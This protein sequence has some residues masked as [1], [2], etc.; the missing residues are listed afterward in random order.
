MPKKIM[1]KYP[2]MSDSDLLDESKLI[3]HKRR[4]P[5]EKLKNIIVAAIQTAERKSSRAILNL[6]ED[7][8]DEMVQLTYKKEGWE[9]FKYFIKYCGDP[10]S[11]ACDYSGRLCSEVAEEQFR[12]RTNQKER[13][14]SA[15]RYQ[16]IAKDAASASG[17]FD[18]VSDIGLHEADFNV[19]IRYS[20]IKSKLAIYISVKNRSNTLGGQDWP[21]AIAALEEEAKGDKN[22]DGEYLCVFGISM[23][24]GLRSI[25]RNQKTGNAYS[26]N[27]ELW[28]SDFFWPFFSNYSYEEVAKLVLE[29][30]LASKHLEVANNYGV[31]KELIDS[32]ED[33]CRKNNLLDTERHFNDPIKL[34]ELFCGKAPNK[35]EQKPKGKKDKK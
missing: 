24:R 13:M 18:S 34:V 28:F 16:F 9:L 5:T 3:P 15:W 6:L 29:V 1:Q 23:E 27:T 32:F 4:I 22:R 10:A 19:V 8:S 11:T 25:R 21:K 20:D 12:L 31:P 7:A 30:L 26:Y 14:N 2:R 17:R 33:C 35:P